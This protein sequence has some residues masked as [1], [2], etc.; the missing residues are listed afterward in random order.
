MA[1][2]M[3]DP[4]EADTP[5]DGDQEDDDE[6]V[7]GNDE[8][9]DSQLG[10][11]DDGAT[12]PSNRTSSVIASSNSLVIVAVPNLDSLA[13]YRNLGYEAVCWQLSSAKPGNG[14]EQVRDNSL[15]TY[16]QSDGQTQPHWIQVHF[17]RR[18]AIS[19]VCLYLDYQADESYTP[20][21]IT[22]HAGM[23]QQ[24]LL[25]A[26]TPVELHEPSGW[27]ILPLQSPIDPFDDYNEGGDEN[28]GGNRSSNGVDEDDKNLTLWSKS[29]Y[30]NKNAVR[31]HMI[32]I[33]IRCMHQNGRD[34]HVRQVRLYGPR[35]RGTLMG[36]HEKHQPAL[37]RKANTSRPDKSN[38][39]FEL[40]GAEF[41]SIHSSRF[42]SIR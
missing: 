27:C 36:H 10:E 23:T 3:V 37:S 28:E 42:T 32:R 17:A 5:L 31:A 13:G 29:N 11:G 7:Q 24:D 34:T 38:E 9:T 26:M 25:E 16:W 8:G 39:G 18:V 6:D 19:H 21:S 33:S 12:V 15:E 1:E 41:E 2:K 35:M 30:N 20:K 4:R 14:V 40:F 22:V